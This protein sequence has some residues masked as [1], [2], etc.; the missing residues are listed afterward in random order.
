LLVFPIFALAEP[1]SVTLPSFRRTV[2][3]LLRPLWFSTSHS[4]PSFPEFGIRPILTPSLRP[5]SPVCRG[6]VRSHLLRHPLNLNRLCLVRRDPSHPTPTFFFPL[7]M[8]LPFFL[9]GKGGV[10]P[11]GVPR[12]VACLCLALP[13]LILASG[14]A[15]VLWLGTLSS[16]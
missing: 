8:K 9:S 16:A 1:F 5:Q 14:F 7:F 10:F 11:P 6:V 12:W 13:D 3:V 2:S 4:G 15:P